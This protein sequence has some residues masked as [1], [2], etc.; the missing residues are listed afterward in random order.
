MTKTDRYQKLVAKFKTHRFSTPELLNPHEVENF[1]FDVVNPWELWQ[2]NLDADIMLIGQDFADSTSLKN[3]LQENWRKEKKSS[4]NSAL[5]NLFS[6]LGHNI[7]EISYDR[8]CNLPL[9]FT[10]AILGIKHTDEEDMSLPVKDI[11]IRE[12]REYLGEL[13]DIVS[14]K[15]IIAMGKTAY[16]AICSLYGI[17]PANSIKDIVETKISLPDGR[18]LFVV[19]HCSPLGR[20][21]RSLEL[22]TKDWERI[23]DEINPVQR[24]EAREHFSASRDSREVEENFKSKEM[25]KLEELP[26]HLETL[27]LRDWDKVF[28]FIPAIEK[29]E[30]AGKFEG[31]TF[32]GAKIYFGYTASDIMMETVDTIRELRINP[33]FDWMNWKE[34]ENMATSRSFDYSQLDTLTL[35]QLLAA[36]MRAD[37]FTGG[38]LDSCFQRGVIRKILLAL[39]QNVY[40]PELSDSA[41]RY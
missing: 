26:Q 18:N 2:G 5:V 9:F 10:N 4:T 6:I 14:P 16:S 30:D 35:C 22:Q 36:I 11:W 31:G 38:F 20:V 40:N 32:E 15:H 25:I 29:M 34:G 37:R 27:T 21:G 13:I 3:N 33:V 19:Q 12:S 8:K 17:K 41:G 7:T 1:H 39:K 23:R 28:A 24:H